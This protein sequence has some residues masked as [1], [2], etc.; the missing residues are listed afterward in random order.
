MVTT[1]RR[2]RSPPLTTG[3]PSTS[4]LPGFEEGRG[5]M[6]GPEADETD[7]GPIDRIAVL[8]P[9]PLPEPFDYR[10]PSSWALEPGAHVHAPLGPRLVRGVVWSIERDAPG[11]ANL[12]AIEEVLPAPPLPEETRRFVEWTGKYVCAPAGL[13]L[14]MVVRSPDALYPSPTYPVYTPSGALAT[15]TTAASE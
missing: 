15:K 9:L 12:K 5:A 1:A 14:R 8:F 10:A 11:A 3:G 2:S 7:R 13:I 4:L 6:D